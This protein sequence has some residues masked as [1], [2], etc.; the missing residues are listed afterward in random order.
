MASIQR[1]IVIISCLLFSASSDAQTVIPL[2][3]CS[4]KL[5][6]PYGICTHFTRKSE[7]Y[8]HSTMDRQ[9]RMMHD[10]GINNVRGDIDY[11]S[12]NDNNTGMMDSI[13]EACML[14][15]INFLG[16]ASDSEFYNREWKAFK[17]YLNTF[18]NH[19]ADKFKWV[20]FCNE[21]DLIRQMNVPER[22]L[23]DIKQFY[24]V[25]QKNKRINILLSGFGKVNMPA[26]DSIMA[27]M[28]NRYFD[29]MN[30]HT[31]NV[32]ETIPSL[33]KVIRSNMDKNH[34]NKPVWLTECGMPTQ[35]TNAGKV[36]EREK[37]EDEQARRLTRIFLINFAYGIDKVFWYNFRS[38]EMDS[39]CSEDNFGVVHKD[40]SPKP[41]YYAYK[42]LI[43]MCP[44]GS[45]RPKL[46]L[47]GYLFK[48]EWTRPD[49]KHVI[50]IWLKE[51]TL[52]YY[53]KANS[54][55]F[56]DYLGTMVKPKNNRVVIS[57][58]VLFI[59]TDK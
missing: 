42:T 1:I 11:G 7:R 12:T 52:D 49:K 29:I 53:V 10:I 45:T 51:G 24:K 30:F 46:N 22:Y 43:S 20:E 23:S 17:S 47:D 35:V 32:P 41:A 21:I 28:P 16:V 57:T 3:K 40:L 44:P 31:Y 50:A 27:L 5:E 9:L 18:I 26:F 19:Y 58:G 2:F 6:N 59:I 48:A 4:K 15:D 38:C 56:Y 33:L 54:C 37:K 34:L 14:Y 36:G 39:T 8:D 25:K 13:L 55:R